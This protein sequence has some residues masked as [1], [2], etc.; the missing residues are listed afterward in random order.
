MSWL[1]N[2][3]GGSGNGK[4]TTTT[5]TTQTAE[6]VKE[7]L[8]GVEGDVG[9]LVSPEAQVVS[10]GGGA[11]QAEPWSTVTSTVSSSGVSGEQVQSMM[12][13]LLADSQAQRQSF[14]GFG[15]SLAS[16][17]QEQSKQLGDIVAATKAPEQTA[18]SSVLP[19]VLVGVVLYFILGSK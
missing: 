9:V 8:V 19:L 13:S 4:T 15:E 1:S 16:G 2:V 12:D 7:Q 6:E 3:L 10:P 5:A 14:T 17:L 18:L 11:I